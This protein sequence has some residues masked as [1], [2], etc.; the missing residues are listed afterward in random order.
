MLVRPLSTS[1]CAMGAGA[2]EAMMRSASFV[3]SAPW[4][5]ASTGVSSE[6]SFA[7]IDASHRRT[8]TTIS[9]CV[10]PSN[11]RLGIASGYDTA[12]HEDQELAEHRRGGTPDGVAVH[13]EEVHR[14]VD[15][16]RPPALLAVH[17]GCQ[18]VL[19]GQLDDGLHLAGVGD[20]ADRWLLE[21]AD[22]GNDEAVGRDR[23]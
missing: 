14:V 21:D 17:V 16:E 8:L 15:L 1:L 13:L 18:Q 20:Q 10:S 7:S 22:H 6:S 9:P 12:G 11:V 23:R 2:A 5:I 19:E 3:S 4:L